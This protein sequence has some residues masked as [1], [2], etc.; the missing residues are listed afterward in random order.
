MTDRILL[1][2]EEA[3]QTLGLSRAR[4]YELLTP[5]NGQPS[6]LE[7]ILIGR[8]RR[9][10]LKAIEAFIEAQRRAQGLAV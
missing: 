4:V 9:I 5:R 1:K 10:P 7:S 6:Q 8:S 3:A 2:P